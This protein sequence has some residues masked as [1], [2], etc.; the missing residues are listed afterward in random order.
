MPIFNGMKK[1][2]Q[3]HLNYQDR[4]LALS[5]GH[6][7]KSIKKTIESFSAMGEIFGYCLIAAG[8]AFSR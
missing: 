6:L 4:I 2:S 3:V 8:L 5:L 1:M 7:Y